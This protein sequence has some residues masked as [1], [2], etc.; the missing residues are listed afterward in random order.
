MKIRIA[1][2]TF[3][4]AALVGCAGSLQS[5]D[6]S[7]FRNIA[8]INSFPEEMNYMS[9][10]TTIFNNEYQ[11]V[12]QSDRLKEKLSDLLKNYLEARGYAVTEIE[13]K[14]NIKNESYDLVI[15][16]YPSNSFG[17]ENA[18]GYGVYQR[19]FLGNQS[20]FVTYTFLGLAPYIGGS[21]L[22]GRIRGESLTDISSEVAFKEKWG[23]LTKQEQELILKKVEAN[24]ND[25]MVQAIGKLGI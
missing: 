1:L 8:V 22:S 5:I 20:S 11:N 17:M 25:A 16:I 2:L 12:I 10:G 21:R 23:D 19:S 3:L 14:E 6:P 18:L 4:T 7:S 15:D 9:I 13:G 24:L